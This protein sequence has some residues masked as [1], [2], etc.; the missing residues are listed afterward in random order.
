MI[1][2]SVKKD[3]RAGVKD[4]LEVSDILQSD[5][6]IRSLSVSCSQRRCLVRKNTTGK[7][8]VS[9]SVFFLL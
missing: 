5:N 7:E 3:R 2:K 1:N 6:A 4:A 8:G 9:Q